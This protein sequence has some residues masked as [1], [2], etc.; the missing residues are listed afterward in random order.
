MP[1]DI[2]DRLHNLFSRHLFGDKQI[3]YNNSCDVYLIQNSINNE[4]NAKPPVNHINEQYKL[5]I[6]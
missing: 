3:S 5:S 6:L 1:V 4:P 2:D